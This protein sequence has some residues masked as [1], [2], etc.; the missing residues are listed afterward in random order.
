[1]SNI[2]SEV[3][4]TAV[5]LQTKYKFST[6]L[7]ACSYYTNDGQKLNIKTVSTCFHIHLKHHWIFINAV[8]TIHSLNYFGGTL[9][10]DETPASP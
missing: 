1:V 2:K 4:L 6:L 8:L 5:S 7:I 9:L 10:L 3:S